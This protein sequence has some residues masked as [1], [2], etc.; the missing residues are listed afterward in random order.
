MELKTVESTP[1][2]ADEIVRAARGDYDPEWTANKTVEQLIE[3]SG[4]DTKQEFI[5]RLME[6]GHFGPL[7]HLNIVFSCDGVSRVT[8][9]QITR[10]RH[11]SFDVQS[12]RYVE[13][14]H[15][16]WDVH[17]D[18]YNPESIKDLPDGKYAE[19]YQTSLIESVESYNQLLDEGVHKETARYALPLATKVNLTMSGNLR[20]WLHFLD[21]RLPADVQ[22]ETQQLAEE[23]LSE[24]KDYCP[25]VGEYFDREMNPRKN[26]L[27]PD[28]GQVIND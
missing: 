14:G 22:D 7:E 25:I 4:S 2:P 10:H 26:R 11:L 17:Q 15:G 6:R 13:F 28:G 21:M 8:L 23:V 24:V 16:E 27:A 3:E 9:A 12:L 1:N 18:M 5:E 20:S 19:I